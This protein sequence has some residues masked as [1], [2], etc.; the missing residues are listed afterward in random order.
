[1][2]YDLLDMILYKFDNTNK[3]INEHMEHF[4]FKIDI[5]D[6]LIKKIRAKSPKQ[7]SF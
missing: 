5:L 6:L 4:G 3:P 7:N 1:M 2:V